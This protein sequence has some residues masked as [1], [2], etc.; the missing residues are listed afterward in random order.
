[1]EGG[2]KEGRKEEAA[3]VA[4]V[5]RVRVRVG[6]D[7]VGVGGW[8]GGDPRLPAHSPLKRRG[9]SGIEN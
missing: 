8:R 5:V 6:G 7:G 4:V 9:Q 3:A 1:M 2:P